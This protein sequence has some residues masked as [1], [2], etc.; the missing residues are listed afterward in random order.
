MEKLLE[1]FFVIIT[2]GLMYLAK[3]LYW[4]M[5]AV[6]DLIGLLVFVCMFCGGFFLLS[7]LSSFWIK[8]F[9]LSAALS[10]V[11]FISLAIWKPKRLKGLVSK[12]L[13]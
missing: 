12:I 7:E 4:I 2:S 1:T 11:C 3:T 6:T 8:V 13:D 5:R 9:L 10:F